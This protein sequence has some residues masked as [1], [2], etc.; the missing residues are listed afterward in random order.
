MT[1]EKQLYVKYHV[2]YFGDHRSIVDEYGGV[3][4]D[5][6]HLLRLSDRCVER[7]A[8]L[9]STILHLTWQKAVNRLIVEGYKIIY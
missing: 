4:Y 6:H 2:K 8:E 5:D 9:H 7:L 3:L 1:E